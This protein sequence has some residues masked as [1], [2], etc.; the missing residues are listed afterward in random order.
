VAFLSEEEVFLE[1][2]QSWPAI[3]FGHIVA[4]LSE[5]EVFLELQIGQL[6]FQV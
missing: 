6:T 1:L 2:K 3:R 5:E 4:F